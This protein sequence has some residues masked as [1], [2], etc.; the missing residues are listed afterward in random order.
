[1]FRSD[2]CVLSRCQMAAATQSLASLALRGLTHH[3]LTS[4]AR[5]STMHLSIYNATSRPIDIQVCLYTMMLVRAAVVAVTLKVTHDEKISQPVENRYRYAIYEVEMLLRP[6]SVLAM[7]LSRSSLNPIVQ[8][9][10]MVISQETT[11]PCR[12]LHRSLFHAEYLSKHLS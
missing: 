1:M 5:L 8:T 11:L 3:S 2:H 4:H 12:L 7:R 10:C 9:P 6:T